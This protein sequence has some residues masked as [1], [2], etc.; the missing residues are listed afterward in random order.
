MKLYLTKFSIPEDKG[1]IKEPLFES[2]YE[3]FTHIGI[4]WENTPENSDLRVDLFT[5]MNNRIS[6]DSS[7]VDEYINAKLVLDAMIRE[8]GGDKDKAYADC[9][10]SPQGLENPPKSRLAKA[11]VKVSNEFIAFQL[12][13]GGFTAFGA[14]NYPGYIAGAYIPGEKA[15]YRTSKES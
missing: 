3:L 2:M 12:T 8:H 9:F 4:F 6:I 11:R 13:M 5:F 7:Y 14:E 1:L 10:T 15:P